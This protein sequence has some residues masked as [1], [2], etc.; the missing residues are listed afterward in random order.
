MLGL[1]RDRLERYGLVSRETV[2]DMANGTLENSGAYIAAAVT[3]LAGPDGDGSAVPVG[4][5][6]AA[7]ALR[8]KGIASVREYH[9]TGTRNEI[10]L[11]AAE[12]VLEIVCEALDI[13]RNKQ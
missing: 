5:I 13:E 3:G 1:D 8:E 12:A 11:L 10:R 2:C 9:F 4:T 7:A 6:W